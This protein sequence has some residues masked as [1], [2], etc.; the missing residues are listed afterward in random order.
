MEGRQ[1][2]YGNCALPTQFCCEAKIVLKYSLLKQQEED[3]LLR[4]ISMEYSLRD[5]PQ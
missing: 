5:I 3:G 1:K 4:N 2:I